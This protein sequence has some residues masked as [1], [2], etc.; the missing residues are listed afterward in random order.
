M[1]NYCLKSVSRKAR[2]NKNNIYIVVALFR[3]LTTFSKKKRKKESTERESVG[4]KDNSI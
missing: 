1:Y 3:C 4:R 2:D